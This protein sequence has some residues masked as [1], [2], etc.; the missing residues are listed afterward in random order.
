[1]EYGWETELFA[2]ATPV[3][4]KKMNNC[5]VVIPCADTDEMLLQHLKRLE[6]QGC[7]EFDV[8][9]I[10]QRKPN[11]ESKVNMLFFRENYP[12]GSSG[13]FGVG[14]VLGYTLGYDY[15][16]NAD[17]D[18]LPLSNNL[19]GTLKQTAEREQKLTF[20]LFIS[21]DTG[22]MDKAG[23]GNPNQ[24]GTCTRRLFEGEGFEYFRLF[25]G[26][27]DMEFMERLSM[28]GMI[29]LERSAQIGHKSHVFDSIQL[30]KSRG[31]KSI[32]YKKSEVI[33]SMLF[34]RHC[35][36]RGR[37]LPAFR[38]IMRA[39]SACVK[40]QL[41]HSQYPDIHR[42]VMEA[43]RLNMDGVSP[44][45][46]S[47]IKEEKFGAGSRTLQLFSGGNS[48][49]GII[50]PEKDDP[51]RMGEKGII[52]YLGIAARLLK[53][54][55]SRAD[56]LLPDSRFLDQYASLLNILLLLKPVK[57]SDGK[58]YSSGLSVFQVA[59]NFAATLLLA[60]LF[61]LVILLA[62]F[63]KAGEIDYPITTKNVKK[64]L[65]GF[66]A[67]VKKLDEASKQKN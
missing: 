26:S 43:M 14:Q 15:V 13:G 49:E 30:L 25:K 12:M 55:F 66:L 21:N 44:F 1:M 54:A 38:Y 37:P 8:L 16:M 46:T 33:A 10:S 40:T 58:I 50:F 47:E 4:G 56:Y 59:A 60:P 53:I 57:Y 11:V 34:A 28:K 64:N 62:V 6:A 42:P 20:P 35:I 32:Y 31:N 39:W 41:F 5:A 2:L 27:E 18:A 48:K 61:L 65:A 45:R 9:L 36:L 22:K 7:K 63:V 24:Y 19:I 67:Y 23:S 51:H 17:V 52:G 3:G 29:F